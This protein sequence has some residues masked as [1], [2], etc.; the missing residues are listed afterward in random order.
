MRLA[1][2]APAMAGQSG[3]MFTRVN[4][5]GDTCVNCQPVDDSGFIQFYTCHLTSHGG[6]AGILGGDWPSRM[7]FQNCTINGRML[8]N[9]GSFSIVNST[10]NVSPGQYH[11]IMGSD[12]R[13]RTALVGCNF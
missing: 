1:L 4:F 10:L 13:S 8:L 3:L 9:I 7:Q 12:S 6:Y 2:L 11:V 5:G